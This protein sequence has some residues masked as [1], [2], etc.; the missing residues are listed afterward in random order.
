MYKQTNTRILVPEFDY[1]QPASLEAVYSLLEKYGQEARLIAG[2]TDLLVQMKMEQLSPSVVVSLAGIA[3]LEGVSSKNDGLEI[4]ATTT[5]MDLSRSEGV[6]GSYEGL[7]E[8]CNAFSTVPV[9]VMGTVGGNICNASPASDLSPALIA[10]DAKVKLVSAKGERVVDLE[11][12][13]TGPGKTALEKG[14]VVHSV[15]VPAVEASTGSAFIKVSR[16]VADISQVSVA[17][18]I[19]HDGENVT[20][21]RIALG[22][23]GPTIVRAKTA[24][25]AL[26]GKKLDAAMLE[27]VAEAVK[28]DISPITDVRTTKEYRSQVAG[29]IAVEALKTAWERARGGAIQ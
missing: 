29:G 12:F 11:A 26:I 3:E 15:Q 27:K 7:K 21:C 2:G 18:K 14:E 13:Q 28:G 1:E 5:V 10:F 23:V 8:A 16:V 24:E 6:S 20:D 17:V 9:M 4:G 25:Q 22:A 19:T